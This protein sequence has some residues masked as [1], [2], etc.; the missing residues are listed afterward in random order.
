MIATLSAN[1]PERLRAFRQEFDEIV[2]E[3]YEDNV[4]RQDY[5]MTLARKA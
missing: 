1:D 5:L 3:F 2:S 4:V